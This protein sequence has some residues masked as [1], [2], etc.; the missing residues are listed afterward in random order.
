MA[1]E[2]YKT[3]IY[4]CYKCG[5]CLISSLALPSCPS[6]ERFGFLAYYARGRVD[7]AYGLL[8]KQLDLSE[9]LI[10]IIYSCA[11][12]KTCEDACT[13]QT[14][15]RN[16]DII[17]EMKREAVEK[18]FLPPEIRD[19]LTNIDRYGNPYKEPLEERGK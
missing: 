3:D 10:H 7:V 15:V 11:D 8:N 18:G 9:K 1:L 4:R 12:C 17:L 14:S 16:L 2:D 19:F 5:G 6:G 13:E